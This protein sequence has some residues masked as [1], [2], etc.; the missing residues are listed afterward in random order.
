MLVARSGPAVFHL[1]LQEGERAG[2]PNGSK[3]AVCA[4]ARVESSSDPE[5]RRSAPSTDL[6]RSQAVLVGARAWEALAG[7]GDADAE[8]VGAGV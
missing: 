1:L 4:A 3:R 6:R 2:W 5:D 7:E 8:A